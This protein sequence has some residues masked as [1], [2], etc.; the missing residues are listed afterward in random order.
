[1]RNL[2]GIISIVFY[3]AAF[4]IGFISI[5]QVSQILSVIYLLV[6]IAFTLIISL[7]YCRKCSV[8][9]NCIHHIFGK[10][11]ETLSKPNPKEYNFWDFIAVAVPTAAVIIFPQFWLIDNIVFLLFFWL[12]TVIAGLEVWFFVCNKCLNKKCAMCRNKVEF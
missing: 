5:L 11:S 2:H 12:F 9:N 4:G 6:I 7:T 8:R 3:F 10:I 1:M